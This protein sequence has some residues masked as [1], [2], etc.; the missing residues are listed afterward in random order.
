MS[1]QP[2]GPSVLVVDDEVDICA[3]IADILGDL[4]FRVDT[5]HDGATALELV[6][7]K[8]YD[9]ALLDLKMPGMDGLELFR[10]IKGLRS[11]TISIIV[12]AYANTPSAEEALASG[13]W[14]V[15][16][17]PVD[18]RNLLDLVSD[19][20]DR[21]LI[22]I[23]DDDCELCANLCD[24]LRDCGFR[25]D[26]AHDEARA[27]ELL[28]DRTFHVVLIDIK[29]PDGSGARLFQKV[30]TSSPDTRTILITGYRQET[31]DVIAQALREG[32]EAVCYKP[33]DTSELLRLIGQSARDPN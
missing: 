16:A 29:L 21:P 4:G 5:A 7:R 32:A 28:A 11:G 33:F 20:I 30:H 10:R 8:P 9:L 22:L 3:N 19:A 18:F 12:T 31:S 13:A 1:L 25:V 26:L 15:V 24:L 17:K 14:R 27:V 2:S 6:R 23:V